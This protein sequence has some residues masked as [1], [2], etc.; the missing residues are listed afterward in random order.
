MQEINLNG[1]SHDI[2]K[3]NLEKLKQLFP[4]IVTEN[5]IDFDKLKAVLGEYVEKDEESYRFTW[6]GK[7]DAF[8][9]SQT[10]STG[11]LRP[12]VEES[13][14]WD[15]T[16]NLYIEGDNLEVLKLLQ[17]SYNNK[18]KMIYI[19]PPYNK[20]KDFVYPD[21]WS[22]PIKEYK[23]ITGQID[24]DG[25]VTSSDTEDEGG[26]HTKWLNM[27]YPRLRLARNLLTDDGVIFISIDETEIDNLKKMCYLIFGEENYCG[28][29]IWKN[30]SKNDQ[31]FI[32]IQ[33][34]YIVSF[35]KN[36]VINKGLWQEK[37]EGLDLIYK[38]FNE[39]YTKRGNDWEAIHKDAL[40]WYKQF[41]ESHPVYSSKHYSWMDDR[42]VYFPDN[43]SGPNFGQYRYDVIHPITNKK[44]KEPSSGWR[45][46]EE[47]MK[48]RIKDNL[49]HF[50]KDETT[51]PNNKTYLKNTEYQ[52]LTSIKYKDGRVASKNLALLLGGN[53]FNNPKDVELLAGIFKAVGLKENDIILDFF[54]GSAATAHAVLQLNVELNYNCKYIMVQLPE[55]LDK[56]ILNADARTKKDLIETTS[57][58]DSI[59]K[60]H[61]LTEIGKERIRRAG[62]SIKAE[63]KEK[64]EDYQQKKQSTSEDEKQL[65]MNPDDLDVGFKVFKLDDSN[66]KKWSVDVGEDFY[67]ESKEAQNA[68]LSEMLGFEVDNFVEGRTELDVVYEIML[69]YGLDLTYHIETYN[70]DGTNVYSIGY[71]GL[72]VCLDKNINVELADKIIELIKKLEPSVVRVAVRDSSF[73]SDSDKTNF[74]ET[75]KNSVYA[76]FEDRDDKVDKQN[77]F[78]FITI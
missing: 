64:Y 53:Y 15:T 65:P 34:E 51:V 2:V 60:P 42:G 13:K 46:P 22:D 62:G 54:S 5:N 9:K 1:Q 32:S 66:L 39:F 24:D 61:Y 18:V 43:I 59:N 26:R 19:D 27:M 8:R 67:K 69:K 37:K 48:Q 45:Y 76:Y 30:S 63:L 56:Q 57:F 29:I 72:I 70:Y 20:D 25:N 40:E 11:T 31:A 14:D 75:L 6:H 16:Q 68:I 21:K 28:E 35:A 47:T 41:P 55:D 73:G 58:L 74:K 50:G 3:E 78:K 33:H 4:E 38:S 49:V 77:Q 12:C 44:C 52:S 36:K 7:R 71:G 23:K 17:K 10:P